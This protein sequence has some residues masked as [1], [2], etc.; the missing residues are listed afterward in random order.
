MNN[1]YTKYV[2][3]DL[4][5]KHIAYKTWRA[6]FICL[7]L[8]FAIVQMLPFYIKL[9]ESFQP[10]DLLAAP[11]QVKWWP[12]SFNFSNY[13]LTFQESDL[14]T[15]YKNSI[16]VTVCY[17]VCSSIVI[18]CVGYVLAKKQFRGKNVIFVMFIATMMVP[19]EITMIPNYE[20]MLDLGW[21]ST[22]TALIVPGMLNAFG[23]FLVRQFLSSLPDSVVDA[24]RIDGCNEFNMIVRIIFPLST[25]VLAT[26]T[27]LQAVSVW[28]DYLWPYL[29]LGDPATHTVQLKL[30][31]YNS[32]TGTA[33]DGILKSAGVMITTI[34]IVVIYLIFQKQFLSGIAISGLK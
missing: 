15:G 2:K 5:F 25:S 34:P 3:R 28:N 22:S 21:D 19:G 30:L 29:I 14:L 12:E 20:L 18:L 31:Y 32:L 4:S 23:L 27:I 11:G 10:L 24:A 6:F 8:F 17:I 33:R 9:V 1:N 16:I 26:Y 13:I 7:L